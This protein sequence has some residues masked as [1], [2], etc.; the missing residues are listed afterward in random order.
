VHRVPV[1]TVQEHQRLR[2]LH[3][4]PGQLRPQT[5]A[6]G[7]LH[8]VLVQLRVLGL[9]RRT[10]RCMSAVAMEEFYQLRVCAWTVRPTPATA[11][12]HRP[13]SPPARAMQATRTLMAISA[14]R[15]QSRPTNLPLAPLRA[16][17]VLPI[18]SRVHGKI[19][20]RSLSVQPL[21][22]WSE[23]LHLHCVRRGHVQGR[24]GQRRVRALTREL[25]FATIF[26]DSQTQCLRVQ[27]RLRW[28][29]RRPVRAVR[30]GHVR[31]R[32]ACLECTANSYSVSGA[33]CLAVYLCLAGFYGPSFSRW[34]KSLR[35]TLLTTPLS[36]TLCSSNSHRFNKAPCFY[37]RNFSARQVICTRLYYS[38][39]Q[40][41]G[42]SLTPGV[43]PYIRKTKNLSGNFTYVCTAW[44]P[45]WLALTSRRFASTPCIRA[46]RQLGCARV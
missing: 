39:V 18:K 21:T 33:S 41:T 16:R 6:S 20:L 28:P 36:R 40:I 23:R 43:K 10:L 45:G 27:R 12:P 26:G 3:P 1:V 24:R 22:H 46:G 9:Q 4:L 30:G 29:P 15:A 11:C 17:L 31:A 44:W 34:P 35:T 37:F 14:L 13:P 8:R 25:D 5:T 42:R 2:R 32:R 19:L 38:C 7:E